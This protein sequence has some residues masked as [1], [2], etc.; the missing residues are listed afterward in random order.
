LQR[1]IW[2]PDIAAGYLDVQ[3]KHGW[4]TLKGEVDYQ[5]ESDRA[6]DRIARLRGVTGLTNELKVVQ[7][8]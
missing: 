2:D 4:V 8:L 1:L 5:Y 6:F 7:A 3:V